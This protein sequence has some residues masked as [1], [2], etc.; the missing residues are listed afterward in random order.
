[1]SNALWATFPTADGKASVE[2]CG[3]ARASEPGNASRSAFHLRTV[4]PDTRLTPACQLAC[5]T[6]FTEFCETPLN[7]TSVKWSYQSSIYTW[8][9]LRRIKRENTRTV[10]NL[11]RGTWLAVRKCKQ[12]LLFSLARLQVPAPYT[13]AV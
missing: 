5:C 13:L 4:S 12:L 9:T 6:T 7:P 10:L 1:M 8:L 11:V 3:K 2:H